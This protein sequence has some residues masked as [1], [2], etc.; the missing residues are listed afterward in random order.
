VSPHSTNISFT[1][2]YELKLEAIVPGSAEAKA[3]EN[4]YPELA[5]VA[6]TSTLEQI[7]QCKVD[8]RLEKWA[9]GIQNQG[10]DSS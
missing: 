6:C 8:G 1:V 3:I 9:L 2:I 10:L 5:R 7:R 4:E